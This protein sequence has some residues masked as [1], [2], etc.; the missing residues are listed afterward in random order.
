MAAQIQSTTL[1]DVIKFDFD[2]FTID[3]DNEIASAR[4][5]TC[6]AKI[7]EKAGKTSSFVRHLSTG[8]LTARA[9]SSNVNNLILQRR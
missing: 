8:S 4:S 3:E 2:D 1:P 5:K 9:V 6:R 7:S